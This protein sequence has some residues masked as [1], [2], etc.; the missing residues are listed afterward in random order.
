[1]QVRSILTRMTRTVRGAF[2]GG[3]AGVTVAMAIGYGSF[4]PSVAA[5]QR[6]D[7]GW[8]SVALPAF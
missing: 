3:I 4:S 8:N 1:M 6:A 2:I 5:V 7:V